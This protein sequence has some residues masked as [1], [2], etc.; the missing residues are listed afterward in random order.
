MFDLNNTGWFL[1]FSFE[2]RRGLEVSEII[3]NTHSSL[4]LTDLKKQ[5]FGLQETQLSTKEDMG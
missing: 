5:I 1:F 4:I 2:G 3:V